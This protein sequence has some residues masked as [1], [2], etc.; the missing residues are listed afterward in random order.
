M[1][2]PRIDNITREVIVGGR[3]S[4]KTTRMLEWMAK[5]PG[6]VAFCLNQMEVDRLTH[7]A[8]RLGLD[9][10]PDQFWTFSEGASRARMRPGIRP[11]AVDNADMIL[12]RSLGRRI[13][14]MTIND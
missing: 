4:G 5:H 9:L 10:K 14:F 13:D 1:I 7:E 3:R 8:H 6:A 11:V 2:D 12:E